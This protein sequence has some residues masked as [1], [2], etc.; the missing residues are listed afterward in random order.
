MDENEEKKEWKRQKVKRLMSPQKKRK[1]LSK[2]KRKI[3]TKDNFYYRHRQTKRKQFLEKKMRKTEKT[4][5]ITA[6][7]LS[8]KEKNT[9]MRLH[10]MWLNIKEPSNLILQGSCSI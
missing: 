2:N 4:F 1:I 6:N 5:N 7:T 10:K 3:I 9:Q 8:E